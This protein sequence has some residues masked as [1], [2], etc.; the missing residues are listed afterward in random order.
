MMKFVQIDR[1]TTEKFVLTV[2]IISISAALTVCSLLCFA[3]SLPPLAMTALA[4]QH[5]THCSAGCLHCHDLPAGLV[6]VQIFLC[7]LLNS[8]LI[9]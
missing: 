8:W 9:L 4:G 5:S 3:M 2:S 7:Q 6:S 1:Q